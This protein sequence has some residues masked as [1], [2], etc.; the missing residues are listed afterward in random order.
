M[1]LLLL[2]IT[3]DTFSKI[4]KCHDKSLFF[5]T[6]HI[7]Q[8]KCPLTFITLYVTTFAVQKVYTPTESDSDLSI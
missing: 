6:V 3:Q 8:K 7:K 1:F 5:L 4:M 2:Y